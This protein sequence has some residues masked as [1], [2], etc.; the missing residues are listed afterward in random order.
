MEAH[1]HL[2][3]RGVVLSASELENDLSGCRNRERMENVRFADF[4]HGCARVFIAGLGG[5]FGTVLEEV[6]FHLDRQ[7]AQGLDRVALH[8]PCHSELVLFTSH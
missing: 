8:E 2:I 1:D 3:I 5:E 6:C 7:L 4:L